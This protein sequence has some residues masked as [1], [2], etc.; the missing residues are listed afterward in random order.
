[1]SSSRNACDKTRRS[2]SSRSRYG[3]KRV[4]SEASSALHKASKTH[5]RKSHHVLRLVLCELVV[6]MVGANSA[7][8]MTMTSNSTVAMNSFLTGV[9]SNARAT[10]DVGANPAGT[11][12]PRSRPNVLKTRVVTRTST[13]Q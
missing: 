9:A 8:Q 5:A 2:S 4:T 3:A 11:N 6:E 12:R 1:M 7:N 10:H 13:I